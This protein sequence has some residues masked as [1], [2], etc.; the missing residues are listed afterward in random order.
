MSQTPTNTLSNMGTDFT[1]TIHHDTYPYIS[2]AS[3]PSIP[4]GRSVFIT[5]AS[6]GIGAATAL[7][8]ARAGFSHIAVGARSLPALAQLVPE[9]K[10]AAK[11]AGRAEPRVLVVGVDVTRRESVE[12]AAGRVGA[13]LADEDGEGEDGVGGGGEGR[14]KGGRL[15]DVVVAN[16]GFLES[17]VPAA[18]VEDVDEWW[19]S[20]EVNVLG[21]FLTYRYFAPLLLGPAAS[22]SSSTSAETN[23]AT[24]GNAEEV[25]GAAHDG[26]NASLKTFLI[27]SS[28]GAHNQLVGGSAYRSAKLALLRF[29]EHVA[30]EEQ[31]RGLQVIS[32]HPGGVPTELAWR[33]GEE[34]GRQ[35]LVDT[36]ELAADTIVWLTWE[37]R[38]WLNARY[39]SCNWDMEELEGKRE[40]V[41]RGDLLKVRM[42]VEVGN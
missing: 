16:A 34:L 42:A 27:L 10:A 28:I 18:E 12:E 17:F 7:A 11:N 6:K 4:P 13:F 23:N 8:Y 14:G 2:P 29:A 5:G 35:V 40:E 3:I 36:P 41:V 21:T 30:F 24:T 1:P 31:R 19:R 33:M 9:I 39:V 26:D 38:G 15:L 25:N 22:S 32:I 20:Y 37:R